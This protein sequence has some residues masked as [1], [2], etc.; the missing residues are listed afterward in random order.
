MICW[1]RSHET[2]NQESPINSDSIINVRRSPSPTLARRSLDGLRRSLAS[3]RQIVVYDRERPL[4]PVTGVE[5]AAH[6][7][8]HRNGVRGSA[9]RA[10]NGVVSHHVRMISF[11]RACATGSLASENV[12]E[13][14]QCWPH[15]SQWHFVK[16]GPLKITAT[17]GEQQKGHMF[18]LAI[19]A[20]FGVVREDGVDI[21]PQPENNW[22][23][24]LFESG[25]PAQ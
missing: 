13:K 19:G 18:D 1:I 7:A 10:R 14:V 24:P 4:A 9:A 2:R 6:R 3:F 5:H 11:G 8:D 23:D 15:F 25:S 17:R 12:S 21:N 16:I 20:P 22:G